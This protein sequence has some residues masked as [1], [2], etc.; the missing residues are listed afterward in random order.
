LG[1]GENVKNPYIWIMGDTAQHALY[2]KNLLH[3][4]TKT[5]FWA[6]YHGN[7]TL[8]NLIKEGKHKEASE[9]KNKLWNEI[10]QRVSD[11]PN[12]APHD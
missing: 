8:Q 4:L 10:Q 7:E 1:N 11:H 5:E 2:K 6:A 12:L 3:E 9:E